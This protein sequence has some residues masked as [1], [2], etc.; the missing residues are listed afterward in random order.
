MQ[1]YRFGAVVS[2]PPWKPPASSFLGHLLLHDVLHCGL[3]QMHRAPDTQNSKTKWQ[4]DCD[5]THMQLINQHK[6]TKTYRT[7]AENTRKT[8]C[9]ETKS[10]VDVTQTG[11][12]SAMAH[13]G[14][15]WGE[16]NLK[17]KRRGRKTGRREETNLN[18]LE[19]HES[20]GVVY[21]RTLKSHETLAEH[22]RRQTI[23]KQNGISYHC[24]AFYHL[25]I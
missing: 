8:V 1:T 19:C 25:P 4:D 13:N 24:D 12:L 14:M 21:T 2:A 7:R 15:G 5:W 9:E 18:A 11:I 10:R 23:Q 17:K 6:F 3:E 22:L 20:R 16:I